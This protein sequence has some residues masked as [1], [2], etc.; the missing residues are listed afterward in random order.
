MKK[1]ISLAVLAVAMLT[2]GGCGQSKDKAPE[3][4]TQ[5]A[6]EETAEIVPVE[7][8]AGEYM[9]LGDYKGLTIEN[10]TEK[11]TDEEV[12]DQVEL[13][14]QDYAEYEKITDRDT[15]KEKDYVN[16][17]YTC[18]IDGKVSEDYSEKDVDTQIGNQEYSIEGVYDL[19]K[20]LT[21]A[22]VGEKVTLDFTFP[23]DYDDTA[24]AGKK[25]TM[26]VT[27]NA[28]EKEVIP[29]LTDE[30]IKEN[31][32]CDT[33]EEYKKQT[34]E[35]LEES[36]ASEAEQTLQDTLWE[37]IIENCKQKK[38]F[39]QEI[40]E[41]EVKNQTI[42]NEEIAGYFGMEVDEFFSE[43]YGMSMED[44]AKDRLRTQCAQDLLV[45]AENLAITEEEYET[46][47][48]KYV[49][50]YGYESSEELLETYTEEELREEMLYNKLMST[51]MNYTNVVEGEAKE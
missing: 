8:N 23:K 7:I 44:Y 32:D 43:Y 38:E 28:I 17:D 30:F 27:V 48:Q 21:G 37:K 2:L 9:E 6:S 49:E 22:K 41:Q 40:V 3:A 1:F 16:M 42:A 18:T 45:K 12:N 35:E 24:V 26:E 31:T 5:S 15:V 14:A 25:C 10:T 36:Y 13:L 19:D 51:L 4:T 34:R 33:L 11:V 39:P 20:K 29:E 47:L 46:E 50:D